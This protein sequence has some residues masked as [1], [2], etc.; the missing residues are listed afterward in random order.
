MAAR[1]SFDVMGDGAFG[2]HEGGVDFFGSDETHVSV[3]VAMNDDE[4]AGG[5]SLMAF[6]A[7]A[8]M[9]NFWLHVDFVD[10]DNADISPMGITASYMFQEDVEVALRMEDHDDAADTSTMTIGANYYQVL[11][12]AVKWSLHFQSVSSDNSALETDSVGVGLTVNV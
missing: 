11:P 10:A 9:S 6:E 2:K 8:A 4:D 3:A 7:A 1:A 12:H 5:D